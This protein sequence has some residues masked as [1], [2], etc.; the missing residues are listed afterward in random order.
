MR[1]KLM[2]MLGLFFTLLLIGCNKNKHE[3]KSDWMSDE[4]NHWYKCS[5]SKREYVE[6]HEFGDWIEKTAAGVDQ[7]REISRK[8]DVCE[9]EEVKSFKD[10]KTN[11]KYRIVIK[12]ILVINGVKYIQVNVVKGTINVGDN[13]EIDGIEGTFIIEKI[14]NKVEVDKQL[15]AI[16]LQSY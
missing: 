1:R 13:V 10:S 14:I 16:K 5:C 2:I 4:N 15:M 12:D 6:A 11:G 7:D 3:A 8:C 9:Y